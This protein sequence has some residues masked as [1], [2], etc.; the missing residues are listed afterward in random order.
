MRA[1]IPNDHFSHLVKD[2]FLCRLIQLILTLSMVLIAHY[3]S[4]VLGADPSLFDQLSRAIV[5]L[6]ITDSS[7]W[8]SVGTG[9]FVAYGESTYLVTTRHIAGK[10]ALLYSRVRVRNRINDSLEVIELRIPSSAWT[11]HEIDSSSNTWYVDVAVTRLQG[12]NDRSVL[13]IPSGWLDTVDPEP[14]EVV[15]LFGFPLQIGIRDSIQSPIGRSGM[16][17][18]KQCGDQFNIENRW[19][20]NELATL[21]DTRADPGMSG[22]PLIRQDR[23]GASRLAGIQFWSSKKLAFA[24]C[25]PVS[26]IRET[27]RRDSISPK[28]TSKLAKWYPLVRH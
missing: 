3:P 6:E 18:C 28:D 7:G 12:I 10:Y 22:C 9:F 20:L 5:R 21:V 8:Q 17:A 14:P 4:E 24:A 15:S 1:T 11:F 16:V 27:L 2:D 23:I 26:R 13:Q 19:A 25:E